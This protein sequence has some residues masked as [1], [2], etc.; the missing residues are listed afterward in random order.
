MRTARS[1]RDWRNDLVANPRF[2]SFA[3]RFPL[4]RSVAARQARESFDLAAG[5]VYSQILLACVELNLFERLRAG[6]RTLGDLAAEVSLSNAATERLLLAAAALGLVESRGAGLFALGMKGAA[7]LGN[8]GALAMVAHHRMVYGDIADPVALLRHGPNH[9]G[10]AHFWAYARSGARHAI[11]DERVRAYSA[12]MDESQTLVRTDVLDSCPLAGVRVMM[13]VGGGEGGFLAAAAERHPHLNG[14]LVDLPAVAARARANF[15]SRGL[16]ERLTAHGRDFFV[17]PLPQG[18]DLASLV[19]VLH[20]HDDA[21][22]MALL[23]AIRAALVPGGRLLVA[24]PM[25]QAPGAERMGDAYF[26]FYLLA[27]GSGRPRAAAEIKAMLK[28]AGFAHVRDVRT[29][30]PLLVSVIEAS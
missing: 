7:F 30:R 1:W 27:M 3:A 11:Q 15:E 12:L 10:L 29:P 25:A 5:F 20:D 17:E 24:E 13:D 14:L 6:P 21:P 2:Q 4:T 28:Q 23:R 18:A 22:A 19:R 8:P 16:A 26:G 9:G